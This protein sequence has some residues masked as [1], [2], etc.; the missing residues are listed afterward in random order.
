MKF[1]FTKPYSI[2]IRGCEVHNFKSGD[3]FDTEDAEAV[4]TIREAKV[5]KEIT[6]KE[7]D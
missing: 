7:K 2:A 1:R 3:E 5:A 4:Q 6:K